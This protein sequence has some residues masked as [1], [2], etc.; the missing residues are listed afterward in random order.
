MLLAKF[1]RASRVLF[2]FLGYEHVFYY[3]LILIS[4]NDKIIR[5]MFQAKNQMFVFYLNYLEVLQILQFQNSNLA[6]FL[7]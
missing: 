7:L 3:D 6:L 1:K 5:F 2:C 4:L